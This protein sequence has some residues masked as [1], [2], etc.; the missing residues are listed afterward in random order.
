MTN[1][2]PQIPIDKGGTPKQGY[3]P[4]KVAL[5]QRASENAV[6]S[7]IWLLGHN[8][9]ELEMTAIGQAT[10]VK[11]MTQAVVDSSVAGTSVLTAVATGNW[12]HVIPSG[13]TRRFVV[14]VATVGYGQSVQGVNRAEGLYPAVAYKTFAGNGSVFTGEF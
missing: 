11:W 4:A 9:T 14:P 10:A 13:E 1:Y 5:T 3:V 8:T 7:S 6:L 2:S 12:D